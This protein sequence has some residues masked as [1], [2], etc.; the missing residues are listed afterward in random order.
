MFYERYLLFTAGKLLGGTPPPKQPSA[1][2][3][4]TVQEPQVGLDGQPLPL[5]SSPITDGILAWP[6]GSKLS[7]HVYLSTNPEGDV[8]EH[9]E[10]LP[11]FVWNDITFG[12]WNEAR[13]INLDVNFPKVRPHTR[14]DIGCA[15][16][17]YCQSVQGNGSM[18][19]DV[20]LVRDNATPNPRSSSYNPLLVHHVR[21]RT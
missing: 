10:P 14:G 13:V 15:D 3:A 19:A 5:Q 9:K 6:F 16:M 20:F 17:G 11:H 1:D 18:W 4:Q 2:V 21:Q 7:M 8:F 12:D